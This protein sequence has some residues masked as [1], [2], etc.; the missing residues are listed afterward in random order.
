MKYPE[1]F[2]P[3]AR[4]RIELK[5]LKA[6]RDLE[7]YRIDPAAR[8]RRQHAVGPY[9]TLWTQ[10][11]EDLHEYILHVTL[12]FGHEACEL[13]LQGVWQVDRI[14]TA[15]TD[16]LR[17]CTIEAR[18]EKGHDKYGHIFPEMVD[19]WGGSLLPQVERTFLESPEWR[20]F[21]DELIA[22]AERQAVS[23]PTLDEPVSSCVA[24]TERT[25]TVTGGKV[26]RSIPELSHRA[27]WLKDRLLERGW[28]NSDPLKYRGPDRKTVEK[29]LRG[30][31]VRNDVLEKLAAALSEKHAKVS[32]FDIP[33]D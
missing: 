13:G 11:Q 8:P 23:K 14:R 32:V 25:A 18:L 20:Q 17:R 1:E 29:I 15:V 2:S 30:E 12:A 3:E 19:N 10:E 22:V 9:G 26:G 28:S 31:P 7:L 16:F 5:K 24:T 27:S 33:K 21:E 4:A 6:G